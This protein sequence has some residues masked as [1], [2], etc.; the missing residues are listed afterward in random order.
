VSPETIALV[1][2]AG[3]LV[4]ILSALFGVGGG[5]LMVPFMVVVLGET[6]HVAEGTSLLVVIPTAVVGVLVHLR[7]GYVSFRLA[8]LVGAGGT[9]GALA[10]SS[11]ALALEGE[12]L[13][14][15]FGVL[16]LGIGARMVQQGTVALREAKR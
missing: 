3:V 14:K 15:I 8:A 2:A 9:L 4:G 10:G 1:I 7:R 16:L 11:L 12:T 13:Q 6:Q 5:L